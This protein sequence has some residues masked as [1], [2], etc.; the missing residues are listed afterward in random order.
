VN[1]LLIFHAALT[2]LL[3]GVIWTVQLVHYPL[4]AQVNGTGFRSYHARHLLRITVLVA[5]LALLEAL[6]AAILVLWGPRNSWLLA[7]LAPMAVNIVST[8]LVQAPLNLQLAKGFDPAL[9]QK[10][11]ST[12]WQRTIAWTVRG[13]C[14]GLALLG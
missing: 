13:F 9:H 5:P 10:L 1:A 11:V 2:W 4:W 14:V 8:F 12:N 6:T 3:A 7:S